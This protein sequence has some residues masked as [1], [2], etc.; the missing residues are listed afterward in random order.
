MTINIDDD[1]PLLPS[2]LD[3]LLDEQEASGS[4]GRGRGARLAELKRAVARDLE[5]LLN[6]R[7]RC[8][9]FPRDL[10]ELRPSL[11]DY[12]VP[13][14]TGS[15]LASTSRK[16]AFRT[17]MERAIKLYE[18]RFK[19]VTVTM[20]ANTNPLDRSLRF[21]I[22]ALLHAEPAPEPLTL[23][24]RIDPVSRACQVRE[25]GYG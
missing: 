18:P 3:R 6:T 19:S 12:G 10:D 11:A 7:R 1:V 25:S 17:A 21:R 2:V 13:D 14:F 8:R 20:V 23:D 9:S 5:N 15:N 4:M 22:E 24:S 16:Q